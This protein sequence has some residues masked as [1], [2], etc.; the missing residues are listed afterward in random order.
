MDIR[1]VLYYAHQSAKPYTHATA[2]DTKKLVTR[3]Y[4]PRDELS[5]HSIVLGE[6]SFKEVLYS[7][8]QNSIVA[9][10][11]PI[12]RYNTCAAVFSASVCVVI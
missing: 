6:L 8:F 5:S 4:T 9:S 12:D 1:Q 7:S 10:C 3:V 2:E 11:I